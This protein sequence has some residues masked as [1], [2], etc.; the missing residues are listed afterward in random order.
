MMKENEAT[1]I[2]KI[3]PNEA[4]ENTKDLEAVEPVEGSVIKKEKKGVCKNG[5]F[6]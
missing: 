2:I 1:I 6:F 5:E 3:V 4:V